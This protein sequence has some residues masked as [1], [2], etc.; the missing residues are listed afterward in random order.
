MNVRHDMV[1]VLVVR[2]DSSGKS[3]EFLQLHRV[4]HDY[5][6]GTWQIIRGGV[7][8]DETYVNAALREMTEE[9]GLYPREF[10]RLDSVESFY[11]AVDDT[12]WHS[13]AFCAIVDREERAQ[14]NNEHDDFRWIAREQIERHTMWS[15]ELQLLS[16]LRRTILDNGPAKLFLKIDLPA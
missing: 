9:S 6:G 3:H 15:S 7:N 14:L 2:P 11:T 10:Y 4:A 16:D 13:V 5:M 8:A 1:T 12:L